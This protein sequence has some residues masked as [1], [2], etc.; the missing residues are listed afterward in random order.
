MTTLKKYYR[1]ELAKTQLKTAISLFLNGHD[2][3]SVITLAGAA[4]NILH[5]LVI[6]A[7]KTPFLYYANEV[8]EA[9]NGKTPKRTQYKH[10]IHCILAINDHKHMDSKTPLTCA[11]D[12]LKCA[13]DSLLVAVN[14]YITLYGQEENFIKAYL[15]WN[16]VRTA[17]QDIIDVV[18]NMPE[19]L[20]KNEKW[21]KAIDKKNLRNKKGHRD[22]TLGTRTYHRFQLAENQLITAIKLFLTNSDKLSAI[23]LA[24]AADTIFCELVNRSG[25]DN[26]TDIL[27]KS[28][29]GNYGADIGNE[30]NDLLHINTLK[31]FDED[32]E[33]VI[34][35]EIEETAVAT[36]LKTLVNYNMLDGKNEKLI[37]G[38][39]NWVK[40]NLDPIKYNLCDPEIILVSKLDFQET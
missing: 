19:K 38:F 10:H 1:S 4:S 33:E 17:G 30:I 40:L 5:Q 35:L 21:R 34:E 23:T 39:R 2:L 7:N 15:Q 8:C 13:N 16:W 26:F 37:I 18:D 29:G 22:K 27:S 36:I 14:D 25:K 9:I 28:Q 20:K 31:H 24:G 11:I 3:S 12:L 6:N 32:E